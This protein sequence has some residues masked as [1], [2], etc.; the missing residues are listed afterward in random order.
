MFTKLR[1]VSMLKYILLFHC[2]WTENKPERLHLASFFH[3]KLMFVSEAVN[4]S[5]EWST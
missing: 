5:T 3:S 2:R 4:L 1:Q